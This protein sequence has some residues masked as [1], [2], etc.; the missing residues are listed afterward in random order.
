MKY[1]SSYNYYYVGLYKLDS[2]LKMVAVSSDLLGASDKITSKKCKT[3][4]LL[5]TSRSFS[6]HQASWLCVS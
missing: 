3:R 2:D 5:D 4:Q 6:R 1:I